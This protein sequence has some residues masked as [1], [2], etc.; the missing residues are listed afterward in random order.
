MEKV[1]VE[2]S[3]PVT[4][5]IFEIPEDDSSIV[6]ARLMVN[7]QQ[8]VEQLSVHSFEQAFPKSES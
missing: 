7:V 1:G 2:V 8:V 3:Y 6:R 5:E 4:A